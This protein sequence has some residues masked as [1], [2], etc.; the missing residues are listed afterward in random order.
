MNFFENFTAD[1]R[2][3]IASG[4]TFDI[5]AFPDTT[6]ANREAE[7]IAS[8]VWSSVVDY[9]P[10]VNS[11]KSDQRFSDFGRAEKIAPLSETAYVR[12]LGG[13]RNLQSFERSIDAREQALLGIPAIDK[14]NLLAQLEDRE[15][16]EWWGRQS[17]ETRA[18]QMRLAAETGEGERLALAILRSPIPQADVEKAHLREIWNTARRNADPVE[19]ERIDLGRKSAEWTARNLQ[20]A[21]AVV[22]TVSGWDDDR[23]LSHAITAQDGEF[24]PFAERLGFT[25]Q[26]VARMQLRLSTRR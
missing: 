2:V 20:F 10:Q 19:A 12:L 25:R 17:V 4:H 6:G 1:Q 3:Q 9:V 5:P 13:W 8:A 22:K 18:E 15:I 24:I 21:R 26:D 23:V 11:V 16:R 7:V 14:S